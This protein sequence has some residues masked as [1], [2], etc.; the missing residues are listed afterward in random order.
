MQAKMPRTASKAKLCAIAKIVAVSLFVTFAAPVQTRA[1]T[2]HQHSRQPQT[3]CT[4]PA[5]T[6]GTPSA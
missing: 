6:L 4:A 3:I 1:Q 5:A 2:E